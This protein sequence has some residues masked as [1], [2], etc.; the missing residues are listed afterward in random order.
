MKS[1][2]I[3]R[4]KATRSTAV[5]SSHDIGIMIGG[6]YYLGE[7]NPGKHFNMTKPAF[8]VFYRFNQNYRVA[9]RAGF[10]Y[11]SIMGDDS[12]SDDD[13]QL[14]RNL[15]FKSKL[16]EFNGV[17]EFNFWEYRINNS[18]HFFSPYVFLGFAVVHHKPMAEFQGKYIELQ[19]LATEG[20]GT[21]LDT[22]RKKYKLTQFTIPFGLGAK[23]NLSR[24]VGLSLEWGMRKTF[25]DYLDDVSKQ[26][27][28]PILLAQ[29]KGALSAILSN[30][31]NN[32]D[33]TYNMT[34]TQRGNP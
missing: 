11:G 21:S 24:N 10:N 4:E 19:P 25:T 29:E 32:T 8:G 20:Q 30:R 5:V 9:Y 34:G 3:K 31:S 16:I 17:A 6:S 1:A 28:N 15:N 7:L 18:K 22:K 13:D 33:P 23:L 27:V 14:M 12:Q 26:Y 2:T